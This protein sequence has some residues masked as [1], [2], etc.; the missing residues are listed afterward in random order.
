MVFRPLTFFKTLEM[1]LSK[2]AL[3]FRS[4][5]HLRI[6]LVSLRQTV[7]INCSPLMH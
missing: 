7:N 4:E 6:M 5:G 1:T 2:F 3:V